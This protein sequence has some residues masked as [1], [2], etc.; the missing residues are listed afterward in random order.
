VMPA[1]VQQLMRRNRISAERAGQRQIKNFLGSVRRER[2][3][4]PFYCLGTHHSP[5]SCNVALV[6]FLTAQLKKV[7]EFFPTKEH[8]APQ[9]LPRH[10][11]GSESGPS[12]DNCEVH[13]AC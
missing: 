12:K 13:R 6:P 7:L 11:S 8:R 2:G 5:D 9:N 1:N 3:M 4:R 10:S